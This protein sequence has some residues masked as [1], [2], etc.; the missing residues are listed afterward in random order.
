MSGNTAKLKMINHGDPEELVN[1][2]RENMGE[3][4]SS[5]LSQEDIPSQISKLS[6]LKDK[7]V[8]TEEEFISKK[9]ELLNKM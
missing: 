4:K 6:E 7:G 5:V 8:I 1:Y 2:V 9:T 3:K